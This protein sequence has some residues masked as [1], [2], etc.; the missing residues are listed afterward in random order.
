MFQ[1]GFPLEFYVL[2]DMEAYDV[3]TRKNKVHEEFTTA[4]SQV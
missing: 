1:E 3:A 4:A 2:L